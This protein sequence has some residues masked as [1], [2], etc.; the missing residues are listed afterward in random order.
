MHN[1]IRLFPPFR[2]FHRIRLLDFPALVYFPFKFN[3]SLQ[4]RFLAVIARSPSDPAEK[5]RSKFA[6]NANVNKKLPFCEGPLAPANYCEKTHWANV[7]SLVNQELL[8]VEHKLM[9]NFKDRDDLA[10]AVR[11]K[12][13]QQQQVEDNFSILVLGADSGVTHWSNGQFLIVKVSES[14]TLLML[15]LKLMLMLMLMLMLILMK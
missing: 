9:N 2:L 13:N 7:L 1:Q 14:F 4:P 5:E 8:Q 6:N 11:A 12:M 10:A 3:L 15:M